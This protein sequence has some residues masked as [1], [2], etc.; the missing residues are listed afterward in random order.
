M[1]P[2]V[3]EPATVHAR[4][5]LAFIQD[6]TP[7]FI[8]KFVPQAD[9]EKF[10]I[11]VCCTEGWV[12]CGWIAI[13]KALKPLTGGRKIYARRGGRR[14]RVYRIPKVVVSRSTSVRQPNCHRP[15]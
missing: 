5:L 6:Q 15:L 8:G 1:Y 12:Q 3:P 9:L 4:A 13:A 2:T 11:E 14:F 7:Q 10:Y